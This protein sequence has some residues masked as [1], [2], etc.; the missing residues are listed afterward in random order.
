MVEEKDD[1]EEQEAEP[2]P[3]AKPKVKEDDEGNVT[4][5]L[6]PEP[7]QRPPRRERREQ[8]YE[9]LR[10]YRDEAEALRARVALLEAQGRAQP[11][12][13]QTT[14]P[15]ERDLAEIRT[16]QEMIQSA[17]R[18]GAGTTPD[19]I[20]RLRR[21][22]YDLDAKGRQLD[23]ERIKREL[24]EDLRRD[25]APK[26][27]DYEEKVL[28]S[29]YADVIANPAAMRY[30]FGLHHQMVAEGKPQNLATSR[31]AM[32][33]AAARFGIRQPTASAVSPSQQA[34]YAAVAAQAGTKTTGEV[35]LD[36]SQRKMALARWP[37]LDEHAA[38]ARMAA[39]LQTTLA[40]E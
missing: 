5:D 22:F 23:R 33:K 9:D 29:E 31:E 8:N 37:Q 34:R 24:R 4:V 14:D 19:E 13:A 16:Q 18:A 6:A 3:K 27:G 11:A 40:D 35:R 25:V 1:K 20:E 12:P 32:D 17:L 15:Y 2:E 30:A 10:R 36:G 21:S 26:D 7:K 38:Y 39:L 28:R